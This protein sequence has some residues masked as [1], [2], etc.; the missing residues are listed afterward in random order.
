MV[1]LVIGMGIFRTPSNVARAVSSPTIFFAAWIAGGLIAICGALTYAEIGSRMPETGGYY[2]IFAYAYHPSIAFA[3]NCIILVSNAASLGAVALVGGEYITGVL[4]PQSHSVNRIIDPVNAHHIQTVQ[5]MIAITAIILFYG[6]NLLGLKMSART[7]NVLTVIKIT[8]V[9][10]LI[11]PLFFSSGAAHP[12]VHSSPGSGPLL[13][14]YLKAFGVGLIAVSFTYG[15]YQQTIN[16]GEEV[17]NPKKTIP[18]AI[19][20]G[21][22]LIVILYLLINYAYVKVIGFEEL[23]TAKN[24]AAIMAAK[25]FGVYAEQILSVLLFL[26]VLGYVNVLL[27]SNPRV[28]AAMSD[29]H[30][31]PP[32]FK[33]RN[34]KTEALTTSLTVFTVLCVLI[35]FWAKEFDTILSFT[36]FL[37]CFGMALSA[38]SIFIIRKKTAYLNDSGI[39]MMKLYPLL[40][41]I[42]IAAYTFVGISIFITETKVSLTGLGVLAI[43]ILI[44]FMVAGWQKKKRTF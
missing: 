5:I 28:M 17:R 29:D 21:I 7:Q 11:A 10:L 18:Q 42:F 23:K 30:I 27:M 3:V 44:Y 16:L 35:I 36:I 13:K 38:G 14:E 25:V 33:K 1:S 31:L 40:P 19:S 32:A 2:K 8:M 20:L 34:I 4:I 24:I 41:I 43:F 9:I 37:D 6:V 15:G 26:S 12:F 39:F 22:I